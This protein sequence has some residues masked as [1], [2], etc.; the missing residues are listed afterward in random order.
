MFTFLFFMSSIQGCS[1]IRH[2]V[3]LRGG[4]FSRLGWLVSR[5]LVRGEGDEP[6]FDK[7]LE[8]LGPANVVFGL[9]LQPGDRLADNVCEKVY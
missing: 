8:V 7:V 1:S 6:A 2:G 3:A 4:S 9:I 5:L